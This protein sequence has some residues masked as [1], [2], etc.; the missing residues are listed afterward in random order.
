MAKNITQ[1][2]AKYEEILADLSR[3]PRQDY[4]TKYGIE[5]T[6]VKTKDIEGFEFE[7]LLPEIKPL[8]LNMVI[9]RFEWLRLVCKDWRELTMKILRQNVPRVPKEFLGEFEVT[10]QVPYKE[11]MLTVTESVKVME[12]DEVSLRFKGASLMPL[13]EFSMEE[14]WPKL[15][16]GLEGLTDFVKSYSADCQYVAAETSVS[17]F[18]DCSEQSERIFISRFI[19]FGLFVTKKTLTEGLPED[20]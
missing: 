6:R 10:S 7:K 11:N 13:K 5:D 8:I 18:G 17:T 15:P 16:E 19:G 20:L 4:L 2:K 9:D 12:T 14:H 1:N 3:L